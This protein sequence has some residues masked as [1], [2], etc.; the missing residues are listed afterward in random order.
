[1]AKK[2]TMAAQRNR[3]NNEGVEVWKAAWGA[4]V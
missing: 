2:K 3:S 4:D 1:M